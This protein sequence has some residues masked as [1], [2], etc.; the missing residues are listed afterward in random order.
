[1][2]KTRIMR[3][4]FIAMY[5]LLS[6]GVIAQTTLA[7]DSAIALSLRYHPQLLA[8]QKEL[9]KQTALKSGSFSLPDPQILLEAPTGDFFTPGIQQTFDNPL[10]YVQRSKVGKQQVVLAEAGIIVNKLEV[11]KQVSMAYT[12]LQYAKTRVRQYFIQDSIFKA[13]YIAADK[14]HAAGDAGQ[15]EKTSAQAQ[16]QETALLL[17][18]AKVEWSS[19]K[20]QLA[21]LTGL[22]PSAV[23]VTELTKFPGTDNLN[24]LPSSSPLTD[25]AHR[26]SAVANQQLML[27]KAETAPGFTVGYLNQAHETS[28]TPQRF[29]FGLSVPVWFWTHSSR[30]KA[31]KANVE[32]ANYQSA[33]MVQQFSSAWLDANTA[34]Q[35]HLSAMKYYENTGLQQS[36]TLLDAANR[37]YTA[38]EIGYIEYLFALS[39]AFGIKA[40]YYEAMKNYKTAIIELNYLNG[41]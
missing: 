34:Y 29:Q 33:L 10:V 3:K 1:M 24:V 2:T 41:N 5:L 37:S 31:A 22:D 36:E 7:L 14:R 9:E 38:G 4:L 13:L 30:I 26:N 12:E 20:Q 18:Q 23:S 27:A 19:A 32:K 21:L 17:T 6:S 40:S 11:I 28:P 16:A 15:L 25:Y 39:Q 8:A 35:K